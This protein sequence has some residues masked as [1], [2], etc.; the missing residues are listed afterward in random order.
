VYK[1]QVY[2][3]GE[4]GI[5][6]GAIYTDW[7]EI[8]Y[9]PEQ[10]ELIASGMDFGFTNDFSTL[11]SVYKFNNEIIVDE[12]F[13]QKGLS[14]PQMAKL[15]KSSNAKNAVIYADSSS[16]Q[17]ISEIK[18]FGVHIMGVTKGVTNRV[19]SINYGIQL[20]QQH[21]FKVTKRSTNLIKEL[22]NYTWALNKL[23]ES[24]NE[25]IAIWNHCL[26]ALRYVFLMKFNNKATTFSLKWRR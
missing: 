26:D 25:P 1:R 7:S 12:V 16:P 24:T 20:I 10:A 19:G 6:E 13:C 22:H 3:C 18:S 11:I 2:G 15:I 21:H 17:N 8:D 14:N 23:G 9:L 4:L 5:Q